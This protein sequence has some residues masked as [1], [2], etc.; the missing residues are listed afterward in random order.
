MSTPLMS[1]YRQVKAKYPETILLFRMGDFYETFEEDAKVTAKVLGIVLT[2]RGNGAAGEIP[3]AGFPHHALDSYLPKLLKAGYRVAVCEQMEDPKFAKGIVKRDVIEVVTPGIAFSDKVLERNRNNFLASV[4]LTSPLATSEDPVGF[5]YIDVSTGEFTVS[6]FP[7]KNLAEQIA[8]LQA[9]ELVVQKRDLETVKDLLKEEF[10]G[11]YTKSE[12][13]VFNFDYAYEILINH[14]KT[15]TLKGFGIEEMRIGVVAA[16]A[17]M[18]YLQE[19]QKANLV[20]IRRILPVDVSNYMVLDASTKK[21]LEITAS[22]SGQADGTLFSVIDRTETPMGGRLLK[23]WVNR[24]LKRVEPIRERLLAVQELVNTAAV[25][26]TIKHEL[27]HVG[28]LSRL[29]GRIATGRANPREVNQLKEFLTHIVPLKKHLG[30]AKSAPLKSLWKQLNPMN[31]VVDSMQKALADELPL[32]L[33]DGGVIRKGFNAELDEIRSL[34]T[35]AKE[36]IARQQTHERE[37]T[38]ISSL[39]I[40]YNNVF[41]YYI[42]VTNAHKDKV[43]ADYIRKQTLTN[44]ERYITPE[45][46]EYE[47]KVLHAEEKILALETRLFNE[48][49][50]MIADRAAEEACNHICQARRP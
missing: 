32:S 34:A 26:K 38:C 50:L 20:H 48:L 2:K 22:M 13:W 11:I 33:A 10:K 49:R 12:D 29:M 18:N 41:G 5:S 40:S 3:L 16:G 8:G 30:A 23:F 21:N 31:E 4:A 43:P 9:S 42:E 27:S 47:D 37:R 24:P 39:K 35:G 44:A 6:E 14:F 46:K 28:D 19:T 36:W 25:R 15:K 45:L 17:I 7:L 1:Q